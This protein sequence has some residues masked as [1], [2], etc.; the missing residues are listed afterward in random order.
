MRELARRAPLALS[1]CCLTV[2]VD[3]I[4][5]LLGLS[6]LFCIVPQRDVGSLMLAYRIL[7]SAFVH[8]S[9]PLTICNVLSLGFVIA[10]LERRESRSYLVKLLVFGAVAISGLTFLVDYAVL[11]WLQTHSTR[12]LTSHSHV[13]LYRRVCQPICGL[14]YLVVFLQTLRC[15]DDLMHRRK[16]KHVVFL[17]L[18]PFVPF[19]YITTPVIALILMLAI[20]FFMLTSTPLSLVDDFP[21]LAHVLAM[22]IA[23]I[24]CLSKQKSSATAS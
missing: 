15:V 24:Y 21:R 23:A 16:K 10:S 18:P 2:A 5:L 14:S 20:E 11:A 1:V 3:V 7:T 17:F 8:T 22:V 12:S 13:W 9:L 6:D 4:L 19:P